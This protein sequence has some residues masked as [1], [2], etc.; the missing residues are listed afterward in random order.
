MVEL[1]HRK[2]QEA[3]FFLRC[4]QQELGPNSSSDPRAAG[5]Y[6]SAFLSA[7][8][9]VTLVLES[10]EPAVYPSWSKRWRATLT[11]AE[12]ALLAKFTEGRN[13]ALKREAPRVTERFSQQPGSLPPELQFFFAEVDDG[14]FT[15][16][17]PR[18]L[19]GRLTP[20]HEEEELYPECWRYFEL[21]SRLV[22]DFEAGRPAVTEDPASMAERVKGIVRHLVD[23]WAALLRQRQF[24]QTLS[25]SE[26]LIAALKDTYA[27][28]VHN[29]IGV[30]MVT[31]LFRVVGA[32]ILDND[33]RPASVVNAV[34]LLREEPTLRAL[35]A[36]MVENVKAGPYADE[37]AAESVRR[38]LMADHAAGY[39]RDAQTALQWIESNV[40]KSPFAFTLRTIRN[41]AVAH[42]ELVR[43]GDD[44]KA[45]RIESTGLT[46]GELDAFI[47][48]CTQAVDRLAHLALRQSH[49]FELEPEHAKRWAQEYADALAVG[50]NEEKRR[51][52]EQV[53][54]STDCAQN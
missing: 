51:R 7:A 37:A 54:L 46:Y 47:D 25:S 36:Q 29:A 43:D 30:V 49:A 31:D 41:K 14:D 48:T 24:I 19:R 20:N 27:A 40:L 38:H 17:V 34:S 5:H 45:W 52:A 26:A 3:G 6:L 13:R 28:H 21:L 42:N 9:S 33:T 35:C 12:R 11:E 53:R 2:L 15:P 44:W 39:Y 1:T 50:L 18:S 8:R 22:S 32:L 4:F 10:E 16:G 23:N